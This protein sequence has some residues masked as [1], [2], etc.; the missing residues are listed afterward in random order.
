MTN[1]QGRFAA[2]RE[3]QTAN[4][5]SRRPTWAEVDLAALT[6]NYEVLRHLLVPAA[7]DFGLR[8]SDCG[9][10]NDG[11]FAIRNSQSATASP[12]L[13]P[14]IKANAY[15][16]GAVP[17]ARALAA[18][19][20]TAFAV[21]LIEEGIELREAGIAEEILVLEGAWPGQEAE[22]VKHGLTAAV[23]SAN[24][25]RCLDRE[26]RRAPGPVRVHIKVDTG[27]S[28]L[29]VAWDA[30]EE[31]LL[32]V[33]SAAGLRVAGV[34]SHSACAEEEDCSYTLEQI[35][36]FR[37]ALERIEQSGLAAGEVHFA[38]SAGLLFC[39]PLRTLTA[40]PGIALYGYPPAPE[41]CPVSLK[42][43]LTLKT[44][45]GRI[46]TIRAG[47]SA[48]YSRSFIATRETRAATLPIGY[49]DGYRRG[50]TGIGSV[51]IRNRLAQVLGAVSMDM[52]VVD[53]TDLPDVREEEEVI[54]LGSTADCRM[55]ASAW[56]DLLRTISYEVLCGISPRVP[57]VYLQS[58]Q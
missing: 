57:R 42:P 23:G 50:L 31:L 15:G 37:H 47:A 26:A 3:P 17:V 25:V 5:F 20:A 1:E 30:M 22:V 13:I 21:A 11:Q 40:R 35:R 7:Q 10:N 44:R 55:D 46:H 53:V 38:N 36:R 51:I 58:L 48:G 29:G 32:A 27:M 12:R 14:V 19:G 41:R 34:F 18:A 39:P 2:N 9:L 4:G 6:H 8:I 49:A 24:G 43:A 56:A 54:L 16:H 52:I 28:R 45:V 33:R